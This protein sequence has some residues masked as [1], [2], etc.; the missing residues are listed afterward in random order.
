MTL[1]FSSNP[2]SFNAHV[3][4]VLANYDWGSGDDD[5]PTDEQEPTSELETSLENTEE[6]GGEDT[7]E[8]SSNSVPNLSELFAEDRRVREER[9]QLDS[10]KKKLQSDKEEF[11]KQKLSYNDLS[12]FKAD[13][14]ELAQNDPVSLLNTLGVDSS[15]FTADIAR[16][17][18]NAHVENETP[19]VLAYRKTRELLDKNRHNPDLEQVKQQNAYLQQLQFKKES[20]AYQQKYKGELETLVNSSLDKFPAL[21]NWAQGDT[22]RVVEESFRLAQL[23]AQRRDPNTDPMTPEE[24]LQAL[25][26]VLSPV[27][28]DADTNQP[29][30]KK[31][32]TLN[33]VTTTSSPQRVTVPEHELDIDKRIELALKQFNL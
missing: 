9:L 8:E 24:V 26:T 31:G 1:D 14:A 30:K 3:D 18:W 33:S 2:A 11:E 28:P 23:D 27:K 15:K 12:S 10:E 29:K 22:S 7:T 17:L 21:K 20:E 13:L 16:K 6:E 25:E 5:S 32:I 4:D 19:D